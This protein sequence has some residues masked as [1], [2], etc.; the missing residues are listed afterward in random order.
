[1]NKLIITAG[2]YS[3]DSGAVAL[4]KKEA[5]EAIKDRDALVFAIHFISPS[6]EVIT[7]D[8]NDNLSTVIRKVRSV[9]K[10]NDIWLDIHYN[11][12]NGSVSGVE[13]FINKSMKQVP[14]R[15]AKRIVELSS[16]ILNLPNR[17]VKPENASQHDKLGV[18]NVIDNAVLLERGFIDHKVDNKKTEE[19]RKEWALGTAHILIQELKKLREAE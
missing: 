8:D 12:Y 17:G 2:H 15:I 9:A 16:K 19:L 5:E 3:L 6:A 4:G 11:S 10:Q 7:D 14:K 18:L 1:M 13:A